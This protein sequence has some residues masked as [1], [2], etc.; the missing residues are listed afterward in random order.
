MKLNEN[1]KKI[2]MTKLA[3][4]NIATCSLCNQNNWSVND[5]IFELR[6]F[7]NGNTIF[8]NALKLG[9]LDN[10]NEGVS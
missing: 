4:L 10:K 1:Q 7:N 2:L 9:I 8:L 6:E 3:K 5:N